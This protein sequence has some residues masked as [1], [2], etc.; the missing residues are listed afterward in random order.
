[1]LLFDQNLSPKLPRQLSDVFPG[2]R[3]VDEVGLERADEGEVWTWAATAGLSIVSKDSD[4][5]ERSLLLGPPPKVIWIR[6]GNC[7]SEGILSLL[8]E[9]QQDIIAF[10]KDPKSAILELL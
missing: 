3:H 1:M 9:S 2:S 8:R 6:R 10:L 4:F 7:S 5:Q